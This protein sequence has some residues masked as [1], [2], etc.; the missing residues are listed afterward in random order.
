MPH[1]SSATLR[2]D[3][4]KLFVGGLV[5]LLVWEVFANPITSYFVGGPLQPPALVISL[6]K[7]LFGI[8][9]GWPAATALHYLTGIV[10]YPLGYY[11]LTRVLRSFGTLVDGTIWGVITWILALGVFASLAGLPFMLNW[12]KLTWFSLIGHVIY[13]VVAAWVFET[14]RRRGVAATA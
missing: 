6:F 3:L 11:A 13:A 4:P 7:N 14:W 5:G 1:V 8:H 2:A 9:P 10:F 12:V